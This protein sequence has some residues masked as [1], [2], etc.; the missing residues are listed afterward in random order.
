MADFG[1]TFKVTGVKE[2][3]G[4]IHGE[5]GKANKQAASIVQRYAR[6]IQADAKANAPQSPNGIP[7]GTALGAPAPPSGSLKGSITMKSY[8]DGL[9]AMIYPEQSKAKYRHFA[10]MGTKNRFQ[11]NVP[12]YYMDRKTREWQI[13]RT[14]NVGSYK[15][16]F[17][18][19]T[20]KNRNVGGYNREMKKIYN[21]KRS[22]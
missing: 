4:N 8:F 5:V 3:I 19:Q 7:K 10:E 22:V 9:G 14:G 18:M 17:F 16:K 2:T 11:K 20:A 12:T 13:N 1:M 21:V 15:G 6:K